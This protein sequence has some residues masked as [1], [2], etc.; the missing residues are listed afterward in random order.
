MPECKNVSGLPAAVLMLGSW[1]VG[2]YFYPV[3]THWKVW[4][5]TPRPLGR[6]SGP[7]CCWGGGGQGAALDSG[8]PGLSLEGPFSCPHTPDG[9]LRWPSPQLRGARGG[10][11]PCPMEQQAGPAGAL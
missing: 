2:F 1:G 7:I 3:F 8:L 11:A 6:G 5:G 9:G 10:E 4:E